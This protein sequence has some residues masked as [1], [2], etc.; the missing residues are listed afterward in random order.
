MIPDSKRDYYAG[1]LIA[2]IGAGAA[3]EGSKYGIGSLAQ[4]ES[5]FF[6]AVLG[7]GMILVGA[8]IA[9]AGSGGAGPATTG[10]EDPHHATPS[11]MDWRGWAAI[12]AGVCLFMLFSEYLGLLPAIFACVFVSAMG[13]RTT[14]VK[15]ALVLATCVTVFGIA[16]FAY[17]LKIQ[18]PILRG[19]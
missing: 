3:Y 4:M 7:G 6:P 16:L 19:M 13:S 2:L 18:I 14:T 10:L 8:A 5:G 11:S 15:E 17:G 9:V 1:A 12:I